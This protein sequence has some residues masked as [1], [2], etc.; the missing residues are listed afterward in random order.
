MPLSLTS[1]HYTPEG[2]M[3]KPGPEGGRR[4]WSG[5]SD[6]PARGPAGPLTGEVACRAA[7]RV[8]GSRCRR[9][10][11]DAGPKALAEG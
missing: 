11:A 10:G 5:C 2:Y 1:V 4:L 8:A 6:V 9:Q 7:G 3:A